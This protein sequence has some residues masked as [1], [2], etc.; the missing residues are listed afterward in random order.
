MTGCEIMMAVYDVET[1]KM[2]ALRSTENFEQRYLG[3]VR[4]EEC[5][6]VN[7]V[8]FIII[9]RAVLQ[10]LCNRDRTGKIEAH[11]QHLVDDEGSR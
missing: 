10:V 6:T 9:D 4:S 2:T 5:F 11:P 3:N 8:S 1:R 7:D